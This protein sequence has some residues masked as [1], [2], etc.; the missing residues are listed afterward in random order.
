M[1]DG[2]SNREARTDR[3]RPVGRPAPDAGH[4]PTPQRRSKTRVAL[5][6]VAVLAI[7]AAAVSTGSALTGNPTSAGAVQVS[8]VPVGTTG[9]ANSHSPTASATT[10]TTTGPAQMF[11]TP[12]TSQL[13]AGSGQVGSGVVSG[14]GS[15]NGG[16]S[17][18]GS[19]NPPPA[20]PKPVKTSPPST[21][22]NISG[23]ISCDANLV[24]GVWVA[25]SVGSKYASWQAIGNDSSAKYWTTLPENEAY[26]LHVGCGGT[27]SSWGV[28]CYSNQVSGTENSF[29]CYDASGDGSKYGQCF[30]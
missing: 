7:C 22:I 11:T 19:N 6:T 29:S 12:A 18:G 26:S 9:A 2:R 5:V 30:S 1:A 17:G 3:L 13:P 23:T 15:Q 27:P 10:P 20:P 28:A 21:P 14:G 24:Q 4:G 8:I 25:T 16:S